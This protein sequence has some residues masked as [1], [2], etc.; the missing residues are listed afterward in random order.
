MARKYKISLSIKDMGDMKNHLLEEKK[1]LEEKNKK[2]VQTLVD[3]GKTIVETNI[4]K[5]DYPYGTGETENSVRTEVEPSKGR[6]YIPDDV[7]Q[8]QFIEFGTGIVGQNAPHP[9]KPADWIYDKN[10]HGEEGWWYMGNDGE[11]HWT[12]GMPSRPFMYES[13]KELRR[14]A[15]TIAREVLKND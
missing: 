7:K 4:K 10:E 2:I 6:I 8:A 9:D 5:Y 1:R 13:N 15:G 12:K 11:Y 3:E 14:K